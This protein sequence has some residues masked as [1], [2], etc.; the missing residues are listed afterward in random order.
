MGVGRRWSTNEIRVSWF[1]LQT[2]SLCTNATLHPPY[3]VY[4]C[5]DHTGNFK[6]SVFT[7]LLPES[8]CVWYCLLPIPVLSTNLFLILI[9]FHVATCLQYI[10]HDAYH[11]YLSHHIL[12]THNETMTRRPPRPLLPPMAPR[13]P[14]ASVPV[15]HHG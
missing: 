12:T 11:L 9:P 13:G 8:V 5:K 1:R 6:L 4:V 10:P 14:P 7:L 3:Y 2:A 15:P